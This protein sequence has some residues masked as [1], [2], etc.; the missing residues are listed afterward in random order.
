MAK[1]TFLPPSISFKK[2]VA[3]SSSRYND[4]KKASTATAL[5]SV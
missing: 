4:V 2:G 1:F 3:Q 5:Q